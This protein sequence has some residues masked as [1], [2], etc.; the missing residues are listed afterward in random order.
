MSD[1]QG[2]VYVLD[3]AAANKAAVKSIRTGLIIGAVLALIAAGVLLAWPGATLVVIGVVFGI[4]I[5]V[6]G[7]SR[8]A[9]GIFGPGLTG[10]GRTL[11]IVLGVLLIAAAIFVFANL[12]TGLAILGI[13]IGLS[14]IL[15]GIATL[16]ESNK[17]ALPIVVGIVSIVAGVVVLFIP[18]GALAALVWIF[19]IFL[20]VVAIFSV[21]GA[22]TVGRAA[23]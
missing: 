18:I 11:S 4:Y 9:F 16:V 23:R 3:G 21:I 17:R 6:R 19:A 7:I 14:W 1:S 22:I 2:I 5:L 10:L 12:V 15:D 13:L 8:L 20:I